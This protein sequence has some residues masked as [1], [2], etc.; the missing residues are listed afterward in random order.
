MIIVPST[1]LMQMSLVLSNMQ[2]NY[3]SSQK[4]KKILDTIMFFWGHITKRIV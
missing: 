4:K 1:E 2:W 3:S